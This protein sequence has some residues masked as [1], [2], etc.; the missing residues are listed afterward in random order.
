MDFD[1]R[2]RIAVYEITYA[3]G[4]PPSAA[5]VALALR[6]D[7][8]DTEASLHRLADAHMLVLE[9]G[10]ADVLMAGPFSAVPTAFAVATPQYAC[11]GNCVW[12]ALGIAAT[13]AC[14]ARV[15]TSCADCGAAETL[16]VEAGAIRA[17]GLM[18]FALPPR[19]WWDDLVFT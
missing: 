1:R 16:R 2:V 5:D 19:R 9:P 18:H 15:D 14:D 13:L 4:R 8:R 11:F 10:S 17:A 6:A 7:V 3:I 12:D